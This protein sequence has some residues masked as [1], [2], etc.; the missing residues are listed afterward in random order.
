MVKGACGI[1]LT[2][3]LFWPVAGW[4]MTHVKVSAEER[5]HLAQQFAEP[6]A[7]Q[8][9]PGERLTYQAGLVCLPLLI[10]AFAFAFRRRPRFFRFVRGAQ[11]AGEAPECPR[12]LLA[13]GW[14]FRMVLE[15]VFAALL[16]YVVWT[17]VRGDAY[18]HLREQPFF[19]H[20]WIAAPVL[21]VCLLG[22]CWCGPD[23]A[24][25][26]WA[27]SLLAAALVTATFTA[28]LL[29]DRDPYLV[30]PHFNVA[31]APVVQV[32][33]GKALL[34]DAFSQY[35]LYPQFLRPL[36]ALTG[37]SV[38]KF[39]AVMGVLTAG[40]L[41]VLWL[42]L[43]RATTHPLAALL[44]FFALVFTAWFHNLP[45]PSPF[46]VLD[47]YYQ[48]FPIRVL[49]PALALPLAWCHFTAPTRWTYWGTM[50]V[51]AAGVLW[52]SDSGLPTFLAWVGTLGYAALAE[53]GL[54]VRLRAL[55]GHGAAAGLALALVVGGYSALVFAFYGAFPR[56]GQF[57]VYQ[58]LFYVSGFYMTPMPYPATWLLVV[59]V[60]LVGLAY[61]AR[62]LAEG[63]ATVKAKLVL[64]V[65]LLG[66]GLFAYYQGRSHPQVLELAWWPAF[67]L[68]AL[69]LDELVP[70][71]KWRFPRPLPCVSAA[72]ILWLLASSTC[73]AFGRAGR[74]WGW[75]RQHLAEAVARPPSAIDGDAALLKAA[76]G[77]REA[78]VLCLWE[79]IVHQ[80]SGVRS[81]SDSSLFQLLLMEDFQKLQRR[82]ES[83]PDVKVLV[84]KGIYQEYY[85]MNAGSK[86]LVDWLRTRY[87][88]TAEGPICYLL[89]SREDLV[90]AG[91]PVP[92]S[93]P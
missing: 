91:A 41:A 81:V 4:I 26:R 57:L 14:L 9:E 49:F 43:R 46:Q 66:A 8:P 71:L 10:F 38:W 3:A 5:E 93:H 2:A 47:L 89:Q 6:T 45:R 87:E 73:G 61:A 11:G 42:F 16:L 82:L 72:I 32:Q 36:F 21:A 85:W 19:R 23:W 75:A 13:L 92:P 56:Y 90:A 53:S 79:P 12:L 31:Y 51:L 1:L 86:P 15:V 44:G 52:N 76:A 35:G 33:Q 37:V 70:L 83:H 80:K 25:A 77:R 69:F 60:Y 64:L 40:C 65:S 68:L 34:V 67:I 20:G 54:R 30:H 55:A 63:R 88:V 84:E 22:F 50:A 74:A 59:L 62:A 27:A 39:S 7:C 28:S 24:P 48:Y 17:S 78:L 58:K 29:S 18:F